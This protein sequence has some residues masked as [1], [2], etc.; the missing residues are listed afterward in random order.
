MDG[1][2][3]PSSDTKTHTEIYKAFTDIGAICH[4]HSTYATAWAQAGRNIP[5]LGTTHAD[6]FYGDIP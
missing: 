1:L 2:L 3:R 6:Y 5:C 4:T